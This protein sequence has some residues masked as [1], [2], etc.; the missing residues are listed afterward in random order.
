MKNKNKAILTEFSILKDGL[1]RLQSPDTEVLRDHLPQYQTFYKNKLPLAILP[2]NYGK[3]ISHISNSYIIVLSKNSMCVLEVITKDNKTTNTVRYFKNGEHTLS[4]V[5]SIVNDKEFIREIGKSTYHIE[6]DKGTIVRIFKTKKIIKAVD[7][8]S[9]KF[10][11][12]ESITKTKTNTDTIN[13]YTDIDSI[14][15]KEISD[16]TVKK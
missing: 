4:W 3:I 7:N 12:I 8:E 9:L 6:S 16:K 15:L 14:L 1:E 11:D 10:V 2:E 5:D 13:N